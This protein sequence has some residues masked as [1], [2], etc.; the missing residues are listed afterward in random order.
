MRDAKGR[1]IKGH[2]FWLGKEKPKG[3][4][5]KIS[6]S[7]KRLWQNPEYRKHMVQVHKKEIVSSSTGLKINNKA[8]CRDCGRVLTTNDGI[9]CRWHVKVGNRSHLWKGDSV[10]YRGLHKWIELRLGKP[11]LCQLC[12]T[13]TAKNYQWANISHLYKRDLTDWLRLCIPCHVKYDRG[14]ISLVIDKPL[15]S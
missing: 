2:T 8:K 3:V 15:I 6:K 7:I 4:V 1:F 13:T 14:L 9:Y 12:K 5:K 10:S 11:R